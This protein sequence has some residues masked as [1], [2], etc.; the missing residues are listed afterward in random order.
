MHSLLI[1]YNLANKRLAVYG[2]NLIS[3]QKSGFLG[4][5]ILYHILYMYCILADDKLY[6]Y[7]RERAF[8]IVGGLS[9]VFSTD[10]YGMWIQFC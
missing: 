9:S 2:Y 1:G 6:A 3:C 10:I 4:R 7:T 8:Q 5:S